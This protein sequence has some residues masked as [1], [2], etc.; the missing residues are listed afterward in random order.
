MTVYLDTSVILSR[1]LGQ[2]NALSAWGEWRRAYTSEI[3]RV[4]FLRTVD[5][6]RLGGQVDDDERVALHQHFRVLWEATHRIA[7]SPA[8]L[9]R[10]SEPFPTVVGT[11]DAL[12]LSSALAVQGAPE[13]DIT[14]L[15]HD[16]QL[17]RAVAAIGLSV[18]GV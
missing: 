13:R 16:E 10:A 6:L 8:V 18:V 17:A 1:F 3:T 4:E 5:R 2:A 12:H 14:F 9:D 11:L 7:L 15:T